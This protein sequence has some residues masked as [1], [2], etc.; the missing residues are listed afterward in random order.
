MMNPFCNT[1]IQFLTKKSLEKNILSITCESMVLILSETAAKRWKLFS[2]IDQ[3]KTNNAVVWIKKINENPTQQDII[4]ACSQIEM[5]KINLI[6]VIGGGSAIDLAKGISA[7]YEPQTKLLDVGSLTQAIENKEYSKKER[8]IKIIAVPTTAGTGSELTQ[9]ATIWD[10]KHRK[11]YSIDSHHLKP[12]QAYI[13]PELT[14]SLSTELTLSTGLDA[15]SHA[16]EAYWSKHTNPLVQ[17]ISYRS[18]QLILE[19]LPEVLEDLS[20]YGLRENMSKASVLAGLAFSYTRTTACHAISYPL[21]MN[22]GV[23]HGFAVAM[24][25]CEVAKINN[26]SFPNDFRFFKLFNEYGG[27]ENWFDKTCKS[28]IKL[29][30]STFDIEE[31]DIELLVNGAFTGGRMENN[32]LELTPD[33]VRD[34]LKKVL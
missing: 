1:E 8:F 24:T 17:E 33:S 6:V 13:V 10:V 9:W 11:K 20:N 15:L 7:F 23:P 25:L 5:I 29:R 26:G 32:P 31:S 28:V 27:I 21:S 14:L 18:I 22:Y 2:V 30:L 12:I 16:M 3:V 34:I 19:N 4:D